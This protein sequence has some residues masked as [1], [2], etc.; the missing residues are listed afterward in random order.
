MAMNQ[1]LCEMYGTASEEVQTKTAELELFAKLAADQGIDLTALTPQQ[2]SA[3][4]A[5]T[6]SKA[7]SDDNDEDDE[8]EGDSDPVP[9][10][11]SESEGKEAQARAEHAQAKEAQ[12]KLSEADMMGRVM[13]HAFTNE[14]GEIEQA[15]EA[16]KAEL[17]SRLGGAAKSVA[18]KAKSVAGKAKSDAG[19]FGHGV[20]AAL[21][22]KS[23]PVARR[24]GMQEAAGTRTGKAVGA[25]GALGAAAAAGRASKS[26]ESSALDEF[27]AVQAVKTAEAAGWDTDEC[28]ELLTKADN[29]GYFNGVSEKIAQVEDLGD[30]IHVRGLEMLETVGYPVNWE[31]V[32]GQG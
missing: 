30:A 6:F 32:F 28:I 11:K 22:G 8:E 4:Y 24:L 21:R 19:T 13:A 18:G 1:W 14:L 12:A 23:S 25:A 2:V 27:A 5:E 3:L 9:P 15:K 26:K 29:E 16:G 20:G 31:E 7:A 10:K 17:L